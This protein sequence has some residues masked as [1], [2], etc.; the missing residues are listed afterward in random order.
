MLIGKSHKIIPFLESAQKALSKAYLMSIQCC[1]EPT[2]LNAIETRI[3][4]E[5]VQYQIDKIAMEDAKTSS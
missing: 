5:E 1:K 4:L 2:K 3:A